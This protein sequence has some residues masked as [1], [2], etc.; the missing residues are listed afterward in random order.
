MAKEIIDLSFEDLS[1]L[2]SEHAVLLP[3]SLSATVTIVAES[4]ASL[5]EGKWTLV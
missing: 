3:N 4:N 1:A 5:A 2:T